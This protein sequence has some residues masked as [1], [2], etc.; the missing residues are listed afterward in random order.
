MFEVIVS[1]RFTGWYE[2]LSPA[3][4]E[5]V[6]LAL[7]VAARLGAT[8]DPARH[9]ELLLWFDG[10]SG[11]ESPEL[12]WLLE[13][14]SRALGWGHRIT[15]CLESRAFRERLA[16]LEPE[17]ARDV[18]VLVE[19][20]KRLLVGARIQNTLAAGERA[21]A[22]DSAPGAAQPEPVYWAALEALR[23]VGLSPGLFFDDPTRLREL[24][25]GEGRSR[26][27]LLCGFDVPRRRVI[28]ILGEALD[29]RYYGDSV[30]FA[31]AYF[32]D[33]LAQAEASRAS[34]REHEID[35]SK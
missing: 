13:Q 30:R 16:A 29:R 11:R 14:A 33:Y 10:C 31:E 27:R 25:V 22:G 21:R 28:G 26:S 15:A 6:T 24:Q 23:L 2:G 3:L 17:R 8:I 7:E 20:T 32:R 9:H 5:E 12:A 4:A 18:L 19:R 35:A 1:D 34:A